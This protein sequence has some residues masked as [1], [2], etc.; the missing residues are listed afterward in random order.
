MNSAQLRYLKRLECTFDRL[1]L[2]LLLHGKDTRRAGLINGAA[3]SGWQSGAHVAIDLLSRPDVRRLVAHLAQRALRR[4]QGQ[5][6]KPE[7]GD[8]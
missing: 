7:D 8:G 4:R 3:K 5:A 1:E 2:A 6:E